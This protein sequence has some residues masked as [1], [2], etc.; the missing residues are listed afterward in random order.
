VGFHP[1]L[2]GDLIVSV[3]RIVCLA[4]AAALALSGGKRMMFYLNRNQHSDFGFHILPFVRFAFGFGMPEARRGKLI[5]PLRVRKD[6]APAKLWIKKATRGNQVPLE[7]RCIAR[8][9][10][11]CRDAQPL[12][13]VGIGALFQTP[14]R[15]RLPCQL[16]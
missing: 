5:A 13:F 7:C 15:W 14:G 16:F 3:S 9:S 12:S 8:S 6:L 1:L 11:L 4:A 10:I 2:P